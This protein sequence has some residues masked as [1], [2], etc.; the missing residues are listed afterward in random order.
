MLASPIIP[1]K[2]HSQN[3]SLE[4]ISKSLDSIIEQA[5]RYGVL[6]ELFGYLKQHPNWIRYQRDCQDMTS[7][8]SKEGIS[9]SNRVSGEAV[10]SATCQHD[11]IVDA[12]G[13]HQE[14]E[15][16]VQQSSSNIK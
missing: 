1:Q 16:K 4:I 2:I 7:S 12:I 6:N 5:I 11:D 14:T 10:R 3:S 9:V 15:K 13:H 8:F